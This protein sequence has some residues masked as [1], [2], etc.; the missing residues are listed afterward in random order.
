MR[1]A[2]NGRYVAKASDRLLRVLL[3]PTLTGLREVAFRDSRTASQ[4]AEYWDA[5][6][7]YLQRGDESALRHFEGVVVKDAQGNEIALLTSIQD[8]NR[9]GHAGV[10]SFESLYARTW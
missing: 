6:Q 2:R 5:V 4:T 10:L 7:R 1:K 8:L 3:I 9:L